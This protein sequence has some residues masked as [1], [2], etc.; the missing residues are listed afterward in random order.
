[1][2]NLGYYKLDSIDKELT[3]ESLY[4]GYIYEGKID[5]IRDKNGNQYNG[6][7][8][9]NIKPVC[10]IEDDGKFRLY[11]DIKTV[12]EYEELVNK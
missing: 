10:E 11:E 5:T 2:K 6:M 4:N 1:M 7:G 3:S 8:L 9:W 12:V